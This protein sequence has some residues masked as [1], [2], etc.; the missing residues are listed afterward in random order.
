VVTKFHNKFIKELEITNEIKAYIQ[1]IGLRKTPEVLGLDRRSGIYEDIS[2]K[3][4][5]KIIIKFALG[6]VIDKLCEEYKIL[7]DIN[8]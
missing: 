7:T 4:I 3:L 1:S 2:E 8:L 6:I 5:A